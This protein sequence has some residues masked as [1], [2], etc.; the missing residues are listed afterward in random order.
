MSQ[1]SLVRG[2]EKRLMWKV[3]LAAAALRVTS[4]CPHL[5]IGVFFFFSW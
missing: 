1:D 5:L 2:L 4:H 3:V